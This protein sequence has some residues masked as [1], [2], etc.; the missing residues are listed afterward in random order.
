MNYELLYKLAQENSL[1]EFLKKV[2]SPVEGWVKVDNSTPTPINKFMT[3]MEKYEQRV[4]PNLLNEFGISP[5]KFTQLVVNEVKRDEKLLSAFI[6]NPSSM[7]ASILSGAEIGLAPCNGEFYLIPRNLKQ[8]DGTYKLSVTPQIGYKGL[9]KILLRSGD[10]KNIEAHIVYEGE[11]FSA[12]LGTTPN[13]KHTPKYNIPRTSDKITHGYAI[14]YF[15]TGGFQFQVM[16]RDEIKSVSEM[17]KY[18]NS[19]Y[20]NDK[21]NPNRW[22]ERKCCLTQLA[23]LLDKDY[24]GSK[25]LDLDNKIEVGS[26]FTLDENDKVKIIENN[27][28]PTKF[29]KIYETLLNS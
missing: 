13:I 24:Y 25:A 21:D 4:L 20:F 18:N 10:I 29:R 7:F 17:S 1:E 19:L 27:S 3:M 12:T 22:M 2:R 26:V 5:S 8:L 6:Q 28:K 23:K 16:S 9:I 15:N 14:A 11:R